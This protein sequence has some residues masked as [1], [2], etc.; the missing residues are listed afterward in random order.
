MGGNSFGT[1]FRVTTWG[2]SHGKALGVLIDG[3]P[4]KTELSEED[5]QKE[6]DRR[7][8]GQ[9]GGSSPR[10]ER[11]RVEIL[12][13]VF[14]GKTTGTPI[15]III[16]NEDVNSTPYDEMKDLFRPGHADFT[17]Q[18]KYGIRDHRGGGRASARETVGRVAAG[19][20]AKKILEQEKIRVFAYTIELG[21]I[22]AE[23]IVY[24]EIE[25]NIFRC[26]HRNA[27][28]A[29]EKKVEEVRL[30][31]DTVG[32]I[33]EIQV[34][35]C[36]SGLGE[37]VFDKLEADLAKAL[38]S[39]GA[40]RGVEVGAGFGVARMLGSECNDPIGPEG[41]EKNDAGGILG[42]ISN[43]ADI[44]LR[45]AVKPVPSISI[46]QRT[47]DSSMR[48]VSLQIKGRHDTSPIPRIIPVCEAVVAIV[49]V[50]HLLRQKAI[51]RL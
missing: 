25:R 29:M 35:G 44:I 22:R 50:D 38:M 32:G 51:E 33:V 6:M 2:E 49:L 30:Q 20:V 15:S 16:W 40:V 48:P 13:G 10:K 36:P 9:G 24:D 37:P 27:A 28:M 8:P 4:P 11:D 42:G 14:E 1:L 5:I 41:F 7:R 39:I 21:G 31:G 17:Y 23:K 18:V 19:A 34:R 43:G 47:V 3:C 12:S 45:L 46:E 26:P